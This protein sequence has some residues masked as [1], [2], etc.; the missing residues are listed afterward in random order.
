M[1]C[2]SGIVELK[3][4]N[5]VIMLLSDLGNRDA[6]FEAYQNAALTNLCQLNE[7]EQLRKLKYSTAKADL[8]KN[9]IPLPLN[10]G[11]NM[12]GIVDETG[13]LEYGQVFIQYK[14]LDSPY[15]NTFI[16]LNGKHFLVLSLF[17]KKCF[18]I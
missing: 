16:V 2:F 8:L 11:R 6:V 1:I 13:T 10:E 17:H 3:F 7:N 15:D 12:F 14:D 4:N 9:K 5:Q 18:L